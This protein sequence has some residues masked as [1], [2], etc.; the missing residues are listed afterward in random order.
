MTFPEVL[1]VAVN[2]IFIVTYMEI[3]LWSQRVRKRSA[4]QHEPAQDDDDSVTEG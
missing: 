1:I 3:A 4:S 2:V